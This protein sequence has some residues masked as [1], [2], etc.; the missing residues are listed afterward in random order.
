MHKYL[1]IPRNKRAL[2]FVHHALASPQRRDIISKPHHKDG[3]PDISNT[4]NAHAERASEREGVVSLPG[5]E[6]ARTR[7]M[8]ERASERAREE[9]I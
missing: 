1:F 3:K 9:E 7:N 2:S 4:K 8:R 5:A 6:Q